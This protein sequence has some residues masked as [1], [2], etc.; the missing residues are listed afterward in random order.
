[1]KYSLQESIKFARQVKNKK[2]KDIILSLCDGISTR[3]AKIRWQR[4]QLA[5][6]ERRNK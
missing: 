2:A 5:Y 1:M 4:E 3:N 6:L